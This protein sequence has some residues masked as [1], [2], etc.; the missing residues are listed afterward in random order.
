MPWKRSVKIE[1]SKPFLYIQ[2]VK[3]IPKNADKPYE[4]IGS[5]KLISVSFNIF[6]CITKQN[7]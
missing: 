4:V 2:T 7:I 1:A 5:K 6:N 3:K